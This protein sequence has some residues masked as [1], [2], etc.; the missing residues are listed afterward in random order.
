MRQAMDP[1]KR[2]ARALSPRITKARP[3]EIPR[4]EYGRSIRLIIVQSPL[5]YA[6][7]TTYDSV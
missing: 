7:D 3:G 4:A 6:R 2:P 5:T 1:P